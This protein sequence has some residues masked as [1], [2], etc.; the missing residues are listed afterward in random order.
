MAVSLTVNDVL[1]TIYFK[2]V[3]NENLESIVFLQPYHFYVA[4]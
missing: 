2:T 1:F 3:Y 4:C